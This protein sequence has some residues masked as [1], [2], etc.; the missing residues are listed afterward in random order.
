LPTETLKSATYADGRWTFDLA[1]LDVGAAERLERQL[2]GAG[3]STLAATNP[4]G[5]RMRVAPGPGTQ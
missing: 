5:T 2:A 3:L 1:K 4:T